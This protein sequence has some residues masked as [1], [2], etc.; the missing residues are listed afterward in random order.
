MSANQAFL[1]A[2]RHGGL[3]LRRED[4]GIIAV[5]AKANLVVFEGDSPGMLGWLDPAEAVIT[6]SNIGDVEHVIVDG[7]FVKRDF[8][9]SVKE[10]DSIKKR[11]LRSMR[12]IQKLWKG[13]PYPVLNGLFL[14]VSEYARA[15]TVDT[16]RGPGDG[17]GE[18]NLS[19]GS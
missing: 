14:G 12:R 3:A 16:L 10:Y 1:L 19:W 11:F 6:H 17:I 18:P 15:E 9:L 2:T 8:K 13:I 7:K 5:G 4:L